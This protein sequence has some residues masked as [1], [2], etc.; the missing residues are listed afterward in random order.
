MILFTL[1]S[2]GL[3]TISTKGRTLTFEPLI[4]LLVKTIGNVLAT[5]LLHMRQTCFEWQKTL[6]KEHKE[7]K[8]DSRREWPL[9]NRTEV[10]TGRLRQ[11]VL[12]NRL[13][14][15][16]SWKVITGVL[17]MRKVYVK[18]GPRWLNDD[19]KKCHM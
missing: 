18:M 4:N 14:T 17:G 7:V 15:G 11:L 6:K 1:G 5:V 13:L 9:T 10:N 19:Q 16:H 3:S 2:S 12:G 8:V